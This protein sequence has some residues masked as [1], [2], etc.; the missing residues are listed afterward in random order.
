MCGIAGIISNRRN[1]EKDVK[2]LSN[3]LFSRGPDNSGF[4]IKNNICL[5]H[6]RLSIIDLSNIANQ[7]F[8]DESGIYAIVYNGEAYN[9]QELKKDL[10]NK[11]RKFKSNSDTEVVLNGYLEYGYEFF[12]RINGF[13][14]LCIFDSKEN[15]I[16]LTRD[17]FGKK[18]LYYSLT[19]N[20]FYFCSE[21]NPIVELQTRNPHPNFEGLSHYLWKGYY[22]DDYTAY[23]DIINLLPGEIIKVH[24][25]NETKISLRKVHHSKKINLRIGEKFEKRTTGNIENQILMSIKHRM[26][27]DV[28]VSFLM[29]GGIDSSIITLLASNISNEPLE[30]NYLHFS[31]QNSVFDNIV[32]NLSIKINSNHN[33]IVLEDVNIENSADQMINIF[34]EPFADYSAIPSYEIYRAISNNSK[35]A[36]GGDGAD[37]I[38]LGYKD[39][40]LYLLKHYI[41]KFFISPNISN[42]KT[43]SNFYNLLNSN[44]KLVRNLGYL[45]TAL[46]FDDSVLNNSLSR[47]GW[48]HLYR[49]K[50]MTNKSFNNLGGD[51]VEINEARIF[52]ESGNNIIEKYSNYNLRRLI[53]DFNVKVD[54]TSM[55][56]SLEVRSPFMDRQMIQFINGSNFNNM[57]S[58]NDNKIELKEILKKNNLE[59][60]V[61]VPKAG[62]TPPLVNWIASKNGQSVMKNMISDKDSIIYE[63]FK[64]NKMQNLIKSEKAIKTNFTRLWNLLILHKW[65]KRIYT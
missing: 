35:V 19:N 63:L 15:S 36:I 17:A 58:F 23:K 60:I 12:D 55:A 38:F 20:E 4:L 50:Y 51:G 16:I 32:Q 1:F 18:P 8:Y 22:V 5:V 7:P 40:K 10:E 62:F 25:K 65:Y 3:G 56:N 6:T 44:Y 30:T 39:T 61:K 27:S 41:N 42:H 11:G 47:G 21:I 26:I 45:F 53:Y 48:N 14:S 49:K 57:T 2:K 28:P 34:G 64:K 54:R 31:G 46:L 29:S 13:Y 59:E 33:N 37:E 52:E 24:I 9:F 43:Y